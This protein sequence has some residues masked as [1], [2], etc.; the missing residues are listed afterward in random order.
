MS[1][2]GN[3]E[4]VMFFYFLGTDDPRQN[5]ASR[6][7]TTGGEWVGDRAQSKGVPIWGGGRM[8]SHQNSALL[9]G[10]VVSWREMAWWG[11]VRSGP[12]GGWLGERT[13][14]RG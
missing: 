10:G 6:R 7:P 11:G 1:A 2:N 9:A 12:C 3:E 8:E 4:H 13:P 5:P 14:S